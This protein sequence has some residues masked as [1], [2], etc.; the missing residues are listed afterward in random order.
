MINIANLQRELY[1]CHRHKKLFSFMASK[2]KP[3]FLCWFAK[4]FQ[5]ISLCI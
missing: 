3:L 4:C 5:T 1:I 2:I